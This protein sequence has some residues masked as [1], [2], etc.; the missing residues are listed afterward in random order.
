M[1]RKYEGPAPDKNSINN[2]A[3]IVADLLESTSED[4]IEQ[5]E[6]TRRAKWLRRIT[7]AKE[8]YAQEAEGAEG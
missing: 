2:R 4:A 6:A 3:G 1:V 7:E 8:Q 5:G